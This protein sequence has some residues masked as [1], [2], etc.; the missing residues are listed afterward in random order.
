MTNPEKDLETR[1]SH[2]ITNSLAVVAG[3]L[4]FLRVIGLLPETQNVPDMFPFFSH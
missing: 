4:V 1:A 2:E 3:G